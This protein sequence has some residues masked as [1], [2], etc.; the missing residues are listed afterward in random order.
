MVHMEVDSRSRRSGCML[1][2]VGGMVR[3]GG[4]EWGRKGREERRDK[5]RENNRENQPIYNGV[6]SDQKLAFLLSAFLI[7]ISADFGFW[8]LGERRGGDEKK[9]RELFL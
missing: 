8:I 9:Q 2:G 3:S 6:D 5:E 7:F 4:M 1:V